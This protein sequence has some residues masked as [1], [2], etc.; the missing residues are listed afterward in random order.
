MSH[1]Y[2][3]KLRKTLMKRLLLIALLFA[4]SCGSV[5]ELQTALNDKKKEIKSQNIVTNED[6]MNILAKANRRNSFIYAISKQSVAQVVFPKIVKAGILIGANYGEGFLIRDG[7]VVA[8]IDLAG[9][10]L[11]LQAGAQTYSQVTYIL[12]EERYRELIRNNRLSLNGSIATS[13]S[14]QIQN[15]ILT[16]DAIK[17]DLY[18]IHFNET[19]TIFG[20]SLEGLYYTVRGT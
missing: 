3:I 9:G 17:G 1:D 20:V 19:G 12:S 18:T 10:N 6:A 4:T 5:D 13:V 8:L 14:G 7:E 15:S 11:G 16:T 2:G